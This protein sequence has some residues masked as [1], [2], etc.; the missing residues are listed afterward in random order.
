MRFLEREGEVFYD[1]KYALRLCVERRKTRPLVIVYGKLGLYLQAIEL[2]IDVLLPPRLSLPP[3]PQC[4]WL[5]GR[6]P[7]APAG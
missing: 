2:A 7:G 4:D 6:E 1:L 3:C 5:G